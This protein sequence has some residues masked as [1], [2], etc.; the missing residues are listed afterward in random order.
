MSNQTIIAVPANVEEPG[1]LLIFL[2]TLVSELDKQLGLRTDPAEEPISRFEGVQRVAATPEGKREKALQDLINKVA[3]AAEVSL[4]NYAAPTISAT[5]EQAE[6][7][8]IADRLQL[9]NT[10]VQR[11]IEGLS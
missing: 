2:R 1:E 3:E 6:V 10:A 8:A 4:S 7:Q 11:I 5:Y 9:V